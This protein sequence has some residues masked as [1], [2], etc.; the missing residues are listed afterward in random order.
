MEAVAVVVG[1][2]KICS[3]CF[4]MVDAVVD[5]LVH[6]LLGNKPRYEKDPPRTAEEVIERAA[7]S[8]V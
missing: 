8:G 1:G 2:M 7:S 4:L 6:V 5:E 3:T